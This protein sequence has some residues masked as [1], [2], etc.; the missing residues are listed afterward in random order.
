MDNLPF[1]SGFKSPMLKCFVDLLGTSAVQ[2]SS[3]VFPIQSTRNQEKSIIH[4]CPIELGN[5]A[6][7][8]PN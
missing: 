8:S 1:S 7:I 2:K 3:V 6:G 4:M 5:T